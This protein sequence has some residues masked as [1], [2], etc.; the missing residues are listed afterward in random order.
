MTHLLKPKLT[1]VLVAPLVIVGEE[2]ID[3]LLE[4]Q[5][6]GPSEV[7]DLLVEHKEIAFAYPENYIYDGIKL[8]TKTVR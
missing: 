1:A 4:I 3:S 7:T 5:P 2:E 8:Y 6:A